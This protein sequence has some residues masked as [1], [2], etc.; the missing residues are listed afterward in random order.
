MEAE[1]RATEKVLNHQTSAKEQAESEY[2]QAV[3]DILANCRTHEDITLWWQSH[4][5]SWEPAN[6]RLDLKDA[7]I[8]LGYELLPQERH[9]DL[10]HPEWYYTGETNKT[11]YYLMGLTDLLK[12]LSANNAVVL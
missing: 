12:E 5:A 4:C 3:V 2:V 7:I 6:Y 1:T 9:A 11:A 10:I 8:R